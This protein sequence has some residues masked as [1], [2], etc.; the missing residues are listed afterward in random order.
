MS[1]LLTSDERKIAYGI[2]GEY[3]TMERVCQAQVKKIVEWIESEA[4]HCN[5]TTITSDG[6]YIPFEIAEVL[7]KEL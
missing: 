1:I 4:W 2:E 6:Y 5:G 3:G 7:K